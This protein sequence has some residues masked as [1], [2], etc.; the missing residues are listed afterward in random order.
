MDRLAS[1]FMGNETHKGERAGAT[2]ACHAGRRGSLGCGG[3]T[4]A[5]SSS[6]SAEGASQPCLAVDAPGTRRAW[7]G[8]GVSNMLSVLWG[9]TLVLGRVLHLSCHH[10]RKDSG[11]S[12]L[13]SDNLIS[14]WRQG[15]HAKVKKQVEYFRFLEL[16]TACRVNG[17]FVLRRNVL[18]KV[19][20][21][22]Y[23]N[24]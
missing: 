24:D 13:Y 20:W 18:N 22:V 6:S 16:V 23:C 1:K 21:H 3:A 9:K 4:R 7:E 2:R 12:P 10:P 19:F 17:P 14:A 15:L 8:G 11:C 5:V